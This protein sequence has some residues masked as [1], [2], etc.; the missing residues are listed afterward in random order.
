VGKTAGPQ[1]DDRY[2]IRSCARQP[3][4]VVEKVLDSASAGYRCRSESEELGSV[5]C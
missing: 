1:L 5:A 2:L 4:V 3:L